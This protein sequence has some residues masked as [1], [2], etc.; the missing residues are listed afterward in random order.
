M[1]T[2]RDVPDMALEPEDCWASEEQPVCPICGKECDFFVVD[3]LDGVLGC[4]LCTRQV[5]AWEHT[6]D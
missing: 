1:L 2:G 6:N 4:D 3:R 5:S